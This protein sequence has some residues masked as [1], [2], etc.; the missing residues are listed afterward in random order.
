MYAVAF[1]VDMVNKTRK[2]S[3]VTIVAKPNCSASW[4][5]NQVVLAC[6]SGVSLTIAA[7]FALAG[8]WPILPFA[9]LELLSLGAALYYV[10]W[11]LHYRHV[12]R[13][14]GDTVSIAKGHYHPRQEWQIPLDQARLAVT[15]ENHPWDGPTLSVHDST[16]T[17]AIGDFLNRD[18]SLELLSMLREE[19]RVS[20]HSGT[21]QRDF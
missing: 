19:L 17:I 21:R 7:L 5:S 9:G 16:E 2:R 20:T 13:V 3:V 18:D 15:P 6:L 11:K 8:A 10:S 14:E 12:I 4:R 1:E